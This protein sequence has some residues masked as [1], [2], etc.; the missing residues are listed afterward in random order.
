[1]PFKRIAWQL[2]IEDDFIRVGSKNVSS[3]SLYRRIFE[4]THQTHRSSSVQTCASTMNVSS[5]CVVS[6]GN[7]DT[8]TQ[9]PNTTWQKEEAV[10]PRLD[11]DKVHMRSTANVLI[12][13]D[14]F[15]GWLDART[16]SSM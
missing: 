3:V 2:Y 5:N 12:I 15:S 7:I 1:M 16:P 9:G 6:A 8:L 14:S 4:N 11:I 13:A 10:W